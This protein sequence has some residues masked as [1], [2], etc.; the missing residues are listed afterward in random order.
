MI[1][2]DLPNSRFKISTSG[3]LVPTSGLVPTTVVHFGFPLK[4][5]VVNI[6]L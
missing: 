4:M 1:S 3:L 2:I 6:C 5:Y